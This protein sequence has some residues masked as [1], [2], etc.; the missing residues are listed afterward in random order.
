MVDDMVLSQPS[1][2]LSMH[3]ALH[4]NPRPPTLLFLPRTNSQMIPPGPLY[5]PPLSPEERLSRTTGRFAAPNTVQH[6]T[7]SRDGLLVVSTDGDLWRE[8]Q[9]CG[10]FGKSVGQCG[11]DMEW[12]RVRTGDWTAPARFKKTA[13]MTPV[14]KCSVF[15]SLEFLLLE[16]GSVWVRGWGDVGARITNMSETALASMYGLGGLNAV[17]DANWEDRR[18]A[19]ARGEEPAG[20]FEGD[21]GDE[22]GELMEGDQVYLQVPRRVRGDLEGRRVVDVSAGDTHVACVLEGG[23]VVTWGHNDRLQTGH[24]LS[25]S[26]APKMQPQIGETGALFFE[27]CPLRQP[28]TFLSCLCAEHYTRN[29]LSWTLPRI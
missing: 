24:V 28:R 5:L 1:E 7:I 9:D 21:P 27:L 23:E 19:R 14:A 10:P 26:T 29:A 12:E 2:T 22:G 8:R 25:S 17:Y 4:C 13:A 3:V 20:I 6:V 15:A 16:D 11:E 18:T